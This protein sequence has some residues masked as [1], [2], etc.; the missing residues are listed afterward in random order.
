MPAEEGKLVV[1]A[2]GPDSALDSLAPLFEAVGQRA[3]RLGPAGTATRLKLAV[4]LWVLAVTQGTAETIAFAQSLELNP[5]WVLEAL[6]GG[7]LDL[8]Y[9]RMK[10]KLML[11]D[12][13]PASFALALAA[14]DARLV[15]EAAGSHGADVPVAEAIAERFARATDA[16]YGDEDMAVTYRL[17]RPS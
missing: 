8:P 14:K 3:M 2:S 4:N 7:A 16:G 11:D 1:L 6:G 17:S 13:F 5:E 10:S 15:A 12:D 9:F